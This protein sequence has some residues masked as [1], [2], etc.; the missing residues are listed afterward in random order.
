M[1]AKKTWQQKL[2]DSKDLP[3]IVHNNGEHR[4]WPN[5]S[6]VI[7]APIE[8]K[9]LMER[10]PKGKLATINDLR[11]ALARRHGTDY[12]CPITT[13]IF[14]WITAWAAEEA[15]AQGQKRITPW[16]RT[17]K[18]NGELNAK[19]PGGIESVKQRLEGEGH[20]IIQRRKRFFVENYAE[21]IAVMEPLPAQPPARFAQPPHATSPRPSA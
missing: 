1:R 21:V 7:P 20:R 18:N 5:G 10:V 11:A 9:L 4:N 17:L 15:A 14:A 16:W 13:G 8:V 12:A 3:K 19:Y 6:F 2:E